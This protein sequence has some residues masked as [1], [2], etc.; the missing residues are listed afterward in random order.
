MYVTVHKIPY[1]FQ[2][3]D[4]TSETLDENQSLHDVFG[5]GAVTHASVMV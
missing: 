5:A 3:I 2:C 1:T 4:S